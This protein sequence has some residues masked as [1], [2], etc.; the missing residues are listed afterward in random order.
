MTVRIAIGAVITGVAFALAG[1]RLSRLGRLVLSGAPAPGRTRG[2]LRRLGGAV[3]EVLGQ[4]KLLKRP[5]SGIPHALTFWGFIVLLFTIIEAYGDVFWDKRFAIPAIG[6]SAVLGFLEDLF[7]LVVLAALVTFA[8]IRLVD[9]PA[10][11]KRR[12]RF[13]GSHTRAAWLVLALIAVVMLTLLGYRA[14]QTNTGDFPYGSWAFASHGLGHLL[15]PLGTGVNSVLET[16]LLLCNIAAIMGFLVFLTYSKHLHVFLAPL[17]VAFSRRP[18][19]LGALEVTA[20]TAGA[21]RIEQL[22]WKHLLDLVTCTECGRCQAVCP[23]WNSGKPLSPKLLVMSLR[24]HLLASAPLLLG[25]A[26]GGDGNGSSAKTSALVPDVVDPE[27]LWSC[28]TCG[29]C[30]EQC[31]VDIEHIDTIADLRRKLVEEGRLQ[32]GLQSAFHQ[33]L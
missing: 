32:P 15:H 22:S 13:F 2:A 16:T 20:G 19:A 29:A 9:D 11:R 23:A 12:S 27:I 30:V 26:P 25:G 31:P 28:T 10:K 18:R 8:V 7:T 33:D 6:T 1:W 14:A 24:D 4:R 3:V 5:Q 17:N 21:A